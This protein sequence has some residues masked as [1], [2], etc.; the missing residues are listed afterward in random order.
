ML[1]AAALI[2][3]GP[4]GADP[5]VVLLRKAAEPR[6]AALADAPPIEPNYRRDPGRLTTSGARI[7]IPLAPATTIFMQA[8]KQKEGPQAG[9]PTTVAPS[10]N[11][12]YSVGVSLRW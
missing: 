3:V 9:P 8:R 4:C 2:L 5:G 12:T 1:Y 7:T 10:P 6:W 11:R